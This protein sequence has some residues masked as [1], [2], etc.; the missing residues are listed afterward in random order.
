MFRLFAAG[1]KKDPDYGKLIVARLNARVQPT[2]RGE[3]F[4]DPLDDKLRH[5]SLGRV[6]GGGTQ[7]ADEPDGIAFCDVEVMAKDTSEKTIGVIIETLEECG[8]PKGSKLMIDGGEEKDFGKLEGLGLFVNGTGLPVEVYQNSDINHVIEEC[9]RLLEGIGRHLGYWEGSTE[10]ALY[11]YGCAFERMCA[12]I[13]D[14]VAEYPLL[15][16]ARIV[17][18]A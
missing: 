1:R 2:D 17:Q 8:A 11:F 12:A 18:V 6:T 16:R 13:A 10:T 14:F 3:V 9:E 5:L 7:L 15:D 4:E